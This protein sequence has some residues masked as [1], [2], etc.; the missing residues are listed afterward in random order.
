LKEILSPSTSFWF[1]ISFPFLHFHLLAREIE[2]R[3]DLRARSLVEGAFFFPPGATRDLDLLSRQ[4]PRFVA[5]RETV[6]V[7]SFSFFKRGE[8]SDSSSPWESSSPRLSLLA[9]LARCPIG[10]FLN[11]ALLQTE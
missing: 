6:T 9:P 10:P 11:N 8:E 4:Q 3:R 5:T 1:S 7:F 2:R